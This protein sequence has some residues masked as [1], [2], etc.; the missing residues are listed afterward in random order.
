M[1]AGNWF[2]THTAVPAGFDAFSTGEV[3]RH[4]AYFDAYVRGLGLSWPELLARTAGGADAG[5]ARFS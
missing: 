2:T 1:R 5:A 3:E 4:R